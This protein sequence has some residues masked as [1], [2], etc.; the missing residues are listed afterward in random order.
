LGLALDATIEVIQLHLAIIFIAKWVDDLGIFK[1]P[2]QRFTLA[3]IRRELEKLG[4]ILSE[5]KVFDFAIIV[6]YIGFLWNI[7]LKTVSLP[8]AKREKFLLR[9]QQWII[10]AASGVTAHDTEKLLG[11]LNHVSHIHPIGRSFLCATQTFLNEFR[12]PSRFTTRTPSREVVAEMKTWQQLLS[13]PHATRSLI[14]LEPLD[15]DIWVDASTD[16]GIAIV[17]GMRWRAW[18]LRPNWKTDRRDIGWAESVA[19]EMAI[20]EI[21]AMGAKGKLVKIRSDNQGSIGQYNK[22]RGRNTHTNL[23]I[24]RSAMLMMTEGF[25]IQPEYVRSADNRADG[26]SRGHGLRRD[27]RLP[28]SFE[29]PQELLSVLYDV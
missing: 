6:M 8:E 10:A 28:T 13:I 16:W 26:P 7:Q 9:V 15:P 23:C 25:S 24:R 19:L 1:Y 18:Q 12:S 4:W 22:G 29:T 3:D 20:R 21:A 27:L 5:E 14:P 11:S 2:N 17:H